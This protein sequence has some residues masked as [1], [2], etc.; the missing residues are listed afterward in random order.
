MANLNFP[1]PPIEGVPF[2]APNGVSY[3]YDGTKWVVDVTESNNIQYWTRN[4]PLQELSPRYFGDMVLFS[5]LGVN[6]LADLP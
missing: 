2:M 1:S 6:R 4:D 3:V 5:A